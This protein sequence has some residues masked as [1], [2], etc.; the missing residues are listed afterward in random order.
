M[1][2]RDGLH[3]GGSSK[4]TVGQQGEKSE[5]QSFGVVQLSVSGGPRTDMAR[6]AFQQ[7]IPF[8]LGERGKS[9]VVKK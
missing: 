8:G 6:L 2:G 9:K 1:R 7:V 4:E 5:R 3:V